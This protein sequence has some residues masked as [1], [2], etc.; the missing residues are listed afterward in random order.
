MR[1]YDLPDRVEVKKLRRAYLALES[2]ILRL[3]MVVR[4]IKSAPSFDAAGLAGRGADWVGTLGVKTNCGDH[5]NVGEI[6]T[7]IGWNF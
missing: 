7:A 2:S 4:I 6:E 3:R 5:D 1:T